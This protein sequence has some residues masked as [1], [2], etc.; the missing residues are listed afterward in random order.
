M[1]L[2]TF[3]ITAATIITTAF[4]LAGCSGKTELQMTDYL[5]VSFHGMDGEGTATASFDKSSM[6]ADLISALT[7]DREDISPEEI[8]KDIKDLASFEESIACT[9]N[10]EEGLKNGDKVTV[11]VSF[12]RDLAKSCNIRSVG[13]IE[14]TFEVEGLKEKTVVDAFDSQYFNREDGI[15]LHF[16]GRSPFGGVRIENK[17][18]ADNILFR[19]IYSASPDEN[20]TF[21]DTV[22]IT[23]NLPDELE[24][25][26]YVLK[27]ETLT[28]TADSLDSFVSEL[29]PELWAQ[30]EP[31]CDEALLSELERTFF[32]MDG[33]DSYRFEGD[34]FL[35]FDGLSY[36]P[37]AY[38]ATSRIKEKQDGYNYLIVPYY[39]YGTLPGDIRLGDNETT[40]GYVLIRN[41]VQTSSGEFDEDASTII[42]SDYSYTSPEQAE[43]ECLSMLMETHD[44]ASFSVQ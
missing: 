33:Q 23:A 15:E 8:L 44:F 11:T 7:E 40:T 4:A 43:Q 12:D 21:G 34:D 18:P 3:L 32:I 10:K 16:S 28:L 26:G 31:Y 27:E 1:K 42:V 37:E 2:K 24:E 13:E 9:V 35:S 19:V 20:L 29:T 39:I 30:V 5:I 25:E 6:E 41:F 36:G 17:M 38:I 22:T 14:E